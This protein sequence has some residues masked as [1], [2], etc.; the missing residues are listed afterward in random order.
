MIVAYHP[1]PFTSFKKV[2]SRNITQKLVLKCIKNNILVYSPHTA[3]DNASGGV[4]DWLASGV[5]APQMYA[6]T[7]DRC[8]I[9]E[10]DGKNIQAI[11]ENPGDILHTISPIVSLED[12]EHGAGRGRLVTLQ[13]PQNLWS[14][15]I[16]F[17]LH[18]GLRRV[19]FALGNSLTMSNAT[20]RTVAVQAGSGGSVLK[21]VQA[22]LFVTGEMS[23]HDILAAN[24]KGISVLLAEHSNS[25]R[26]FLYMLLEKLSKSFKPPR[27]FAV[28]ENDS[29][30]ID[31]V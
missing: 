7:P 3:C 25:E 26:P 20:V 18:F 17:K 11:P 13:E 15:V 2:S 16:R 19:R 14:V 12:I 5:I 24:A 29:D 8:G 21:D 6:W 28:S 23:H 9:T 30:P 27:S 1:S 31:I 22:D 4:N 10:Q